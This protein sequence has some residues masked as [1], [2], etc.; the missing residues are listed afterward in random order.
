MADWS[1]VRPAA[2]GRPPRLLAPPLSRL[3]RPRRPAMR[4]CCR[5][6]CRKR[7]GGT[8]VTSKFHAHRDNLTAAGSMG[9]VEARAHQAAQA[10]SGRHPRARRPQMGVLTQG[11][12]A[13]RRLSDP[14]HRPARRV[15]GQSRPAR[16]HRTL[17][18]LCQGRLKSGPLTPVEKWATGVSVARVG[19]SP[20]GGLGAAFRRLTG[21][22]LV[23]CAGTS[24]SV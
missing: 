10:A 24:F 9:G 22:R 4:A 18:P 3:V 6:A 21:H 19:I 12:L 7:W 1:R 14:C 16:V 5:T 2:C 13:H 20:V 17:P 11:V 15:L 23:A 8:A